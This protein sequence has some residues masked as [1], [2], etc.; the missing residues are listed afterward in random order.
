MAVFGLFGVGTWV[1]FT[2][3]FV[4]CLAL[5]ISAASAQ[6]TV[7]G[8]STISAI[9]SIVGLVFVILSLVGLFVFR[10]DTSN[11]YV[12][13]SQTVSGGWQSSYSVMGT[14]PDVRV[15]TSRWMGLGSWLL[16]LLLFGLIAGFS[17]WASSDD[18]STQKGKNIAAGIFSCIGALFVIL[19]YF[20][21]W[22]F[23]TEF[24]AYDDKIYVA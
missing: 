8:R 17:F 18:N 11:G 2:V 5:S 10:A 1:I 14:S 3:V 12:G 6:S 13:T 15:K 21:V 9:S 23:R 7:K 16:L 22:I 24:L 19:C 20:N 4:I